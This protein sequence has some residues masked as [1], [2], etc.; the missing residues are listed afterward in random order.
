MSDEEVGAETIYSTTEYLRE[1]LDF[2]RNKTDNNKEIGV[3]ANLCLID[4]DI[5][6]KDY[7]NGV[8]AV[9][10]YD[11]HHIGEEPYPRRIGA[12]PLSNELFGAKE[13]YL[14][15]IKLANGLMKDY[16]EEELDA[17]VEYFTNITHGGMPNSLS[18][19]EKEE[20]KDI[21]KEI[22][23]DINE[24]LTPETDIDPEDHVPT[25]ANDNSYHC[26]PEEH[27]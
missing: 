11:I 16:L 17:E 15:H 26:C 1:E 22:N 6:E 23:I 7:G 8:N 3:R 4:K 27:R 25:F 20:L 9:M 21:V 2:F 13:E 18:K 14:D 19:E 24:K 5:L 10:R 12:V